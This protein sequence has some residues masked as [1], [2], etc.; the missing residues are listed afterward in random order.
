MG[1]CGGYQM[2]G[3]K[4]LDPHQVESDKTEV[5]GLGLLDVVTEFAP[6]KSTSQVR[7]K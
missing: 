6:E 5:D 3:K 4:I 7:A 2:L 1:I